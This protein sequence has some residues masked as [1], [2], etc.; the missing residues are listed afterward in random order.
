MNEDK[1]DE[2]YICYLLSKPKYGIG[3]EQFM[4]FAK[5]STMLK[6]EG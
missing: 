4:I 2:G 3:C 1:K 6:M 5:N